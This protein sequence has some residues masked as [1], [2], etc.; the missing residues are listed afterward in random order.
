MRNS[1]H[2]Q[3]YS[4]EEAYFSALRLAEREFVDKKLQKS[5]QDKN[6]LF[7]IKPG[8][9]ESKNCINKKFVKRVNFTNTNRPL[10][11]KS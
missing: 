7:I 11:T 5:V 6:K 10:Q 8:E 1:S 2:A 3:A 9:I 4:I